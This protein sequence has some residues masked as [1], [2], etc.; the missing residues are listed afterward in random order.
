LCEVPL[1]P[2]EERH[3]NFSPSFVVREYFLPPPFS[4]RAAPPRPLWF[5]FPDVLLRRIK[6]ILSSF[7]RINVF[8]FS[9]SSLRRA[10]LSPSSPSCSRYV[11]L[12]LSF[13]AVTLPFFSRPQVFLLFSVKR[14]KNDSRRS[15]IF[16]FCYLPCIGFF[17][18]WWRF[19]SLSSLSFF[20]EGGFFP[21][22]SFSDTSPPPPCFFPPR[23]LPLRKFIGS[24]SFSSS[25]FFFS[26]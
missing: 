14:K 13:L 2:Y 3:E 26:I 18:R 10:F 17:H 5:L 6:T 22:S 4:P 19:R 1:P 12:F 11:A 20:N 24:S 16:F 9:S 23:T 15:G 8:F 21:F 7:I 25:G